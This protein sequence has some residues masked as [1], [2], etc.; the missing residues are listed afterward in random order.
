MPRRPDRRHV[1]FL[2]LGAA[3]AARA[4]SGARAEA[5]RDGV[6]VIGTVVILA[7][8]NLSVVRKGKV[9]AIMTVVANL[10]VGDGPLRERIVREIPRVRDSYLRYLD[11]YVD[12]LDMKTAVDVPRLTR[13]L[14]KATD[15]LY[16]SGQA[17]V[18]ITHATMRRM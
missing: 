14:Q 4:P 6:D 7:P 12:Q 10:D 3:F 9:R 5:A 1:L 2:A 16:G 11:P 17:A 15:G 8:F 18:L 13:L